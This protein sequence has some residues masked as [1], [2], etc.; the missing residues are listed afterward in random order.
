[1]AKNWIDKMVGSIAHCWADEMAVTRA[2]SR[3]GWMTVKLV[4]LMAEDWIDNM[5]DLMVGSMSDCWADEMAVTRASS[6]A[7]WMTVKVPG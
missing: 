6:R 4:D 3:V 2:D 5:A 1:M 7:G